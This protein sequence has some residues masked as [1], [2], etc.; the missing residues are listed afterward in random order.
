MYSDVYAEMRKLTASRP[1]PKVNR[2]GPTRD[3]FGSGIE[4]GPAGA[5]G[6]TVG[7][8]AV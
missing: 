6:G 2:I 4:G 5:G 1:T 8:A 7:A 3:S